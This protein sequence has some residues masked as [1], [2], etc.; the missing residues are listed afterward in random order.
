MKLMELF[1]LSFKMRIIFLLLNMIL[2]E[3][4][5][6]EAAEVIGGEKVNT[7]EELIGGVTYM[8]MFLGMSAGGNRM[9]L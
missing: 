5:S 2:W 7:Q 3:L 9:I 1:F 4:R 8:K 6:A